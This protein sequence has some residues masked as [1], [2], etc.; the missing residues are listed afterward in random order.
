MHVDSLLHGAILQSYSYLC[1]VNNTIPMKTFFRLMICAAAACSLATACDKERK[2]RPEPSVSGTEVAV[3]RDIALEVYELIP[4]DDL[5]FF[6]LQMKRDTLQDANAEPFNPLSFNPSVQ[7][8]EIGEDPGLY[9]VL[10]LHCYPL[11]NG[12]WRAY[13]A[14]YGGMDGLCG[15]WDTKAYNYVDGKLSPEKQWVL[16]CPDARA[17]LD[18]SESTVEMAEINEI[19]AK[20]NYSY[21]FSDN[22]L[23]VTIDLDYLTYGE[24]YL[25]DDAERLVL[26][27]V[28]TW[29]YAWN[30][31]RFV[32]VDQDGEPIAGLLDDVDMKIIARALEAPEELDF[33]PNCFKHLNFEGVGAGDELTVRAYPKNDGSW[34]VVKHESGNGNIDMFDYKDGKLTAVEKD[35]FYQLL[36]EFMWANDGAH[37]ELVN[38][39]V[40]VNQ[41]NQIGHEENLAYF[42][43]N[44]ITFGDAD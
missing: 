31:A 19:V 9:G 13:W 6:C 44:G 4:K 17:M 18:I 32:R 7:G 27:A 8:F 29:Y 22:R 40:S 34:R 24:E 33:T 14:A 37:I 25:E 11:E 21:T 35:P 12:G 10:N 28:E 43:W 16:P 15:F 42:R 36:G 30:G 26:P 5:P 3:V 2:Q 23:E 39:A 41:V 20:P 38:D 1:R